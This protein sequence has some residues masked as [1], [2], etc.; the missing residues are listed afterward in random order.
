MKYTTKQAL[1]DDITTEH[2]RL[3]DLLGAIPEQ[4][5]IDPGVWGDDWTLVDLVAHLAEWQSMF[6]TWYHTGL[7][8]G[9][10]AM[11]APGYKWNETPALNRAIREKHRL[12]SADDVY[13]DFEQGYQKIM[14]LARESSAGQLLQSGYYD[15]TGVYPLTTYLGPNTSSHYRFAI[16]VIKRWLRKNRAQNGSNTLRGKEHEPS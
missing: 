7:E 1:I 14:K 11:P 15:W 6:L 10:P 4:Q 2:D 8:R 13:S 16:K 3:C 12:R 9:D 5:W